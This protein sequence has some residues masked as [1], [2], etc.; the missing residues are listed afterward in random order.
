MTRETKYTEADFGALFFMENESQVIRYFAV[1]VPT[2]IGLLNGLVHDYVGGGQRDDAY[3]LSGRI[4]TKDDNDENEE[5]FA[6]K[7]GRDF[8]NLC[9]E[10]LEK[11]ATYDEDSMEYHLL[12]GVER[13][14]RTFTKGEDFLPVDFGNTRW[15]FS[16]V[17]EKKDA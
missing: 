13:E 11:F 2:E 14:G 1:G 5:D 7:M 9:H 6:A 8:E 15:Q 4:L 16:Q 10:Y 17:G 3:A 12:D